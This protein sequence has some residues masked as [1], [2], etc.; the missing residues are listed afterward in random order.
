VV[1]IPA[2]IFAQQ[3]FDHTLADVDFL[4]GGAEIFLSLANIFVAL[5]FRQAIREYTQPPESRP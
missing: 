2:G 1:T 3:V 5:G 4:H